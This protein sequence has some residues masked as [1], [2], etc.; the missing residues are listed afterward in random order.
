MSGFFIP[1]YTGGE[2]ISSGIG[3]GLDRGSKLVLNRANLKFKEKDLEARTNMNAAKQL[4]AEE[5]LA[6]QT[7]MSE[8]T[9]NLKTYAH[10]KELKE[11]RRIRNLKTWSNKLW[12]DYPQLID[13]DGSI[14]NVMFNGLNDLDS[15]KSYKETLGEDASFSDFHQVY[16]GMSQMYDMEVGNQLHDYTGKLRAKGMSN[17]AIWD[18]L[19]VMPG[20]ASWYQRAAVMPNGLQSLTQMGFPTDQEALSKDVGFWSNLPDMSTGGKVFTTSLVTGGGFALNSMANASHNTMVQ[21]ADDFLRAVTKEYQGAKSAYGRYHMQGYID[22]AGKALE[23]A[24]KTG[25]WKHFMS[26][27][28]Y[29]TKLMKKPGKWG[30]VAAGI[31]GGFE[32]LDW[33][34]TSPDESQLSFNQNFSSPTI[35][36][37]SNIGSGGGEKKSGGEMA[38]DTALTGLSYSMFAHPAVKEGLKQYRATGQI[39]PGLKKILQ[40]PTKSNWPNALRAEKN[41]AKAMNLTSKTG[42]M[43]SK[44]KNQPIKALRHLVDKKGYSWVVKQVAKKKGW[45]FATKQLA[46][47][48][49]GT[50]GAVIPEP[51]TTALGAGMIGITAWEIYDLISDI[52]ELLD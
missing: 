27:S 16:P 31:Y 1:K 28:G 52:P 13:P 19:K 12:G 50:A 22:D 43:A 17:D 37:S 11:D 8:Q 25:K 34:T 5:S 3:S 35:G 14:N 41:M 49:L 23:T 36:G 4:L 42:A 32:L 30:L 7:K 47:L 24:K 9:M 46:K 45:W 40:A 26:K 15:W 18:N 6:L 33:S 21:N 20:F 39:T 44:F 48:G 38:M 2:I 29:L 10:E 51:A